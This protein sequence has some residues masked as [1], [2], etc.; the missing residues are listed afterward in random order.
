MHCSKFVVVD[1]SEPIK[2]S[3]DGSSDLRCNCFRN[4]VES[5]SFSQQS[6]QVC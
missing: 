5:E 2:S 6:S 4:I 1:G 3:M